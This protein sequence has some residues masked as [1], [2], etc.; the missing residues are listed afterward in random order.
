MRRF[1][2][3]L[4]GALFLA[5]LSTGHAQIDPEKRRLIQL[6]YNQPLEGR[7]PI[8]GYGFF[9]YNKPGFLRT[10]LTLR[11]A[12]A[13]IYVDTELGF[14]RLLSENTDLGIGFAG[15]G[16]ADSYA[17]MRRGDFVRE[18]SFYGHGGELNTTVYHL[19]N[20]GW[21][22][23]LWGLARASFHNSFYGEDSETADN[24]VVPDD[25][26]SLRFRTGL[27]L[28]GREPTL[29]SPLAMEVSLWYEGIIREEAQLFGF[30]NDRKL[31][32]DSHL[33]W[34]RALLKYTFEP[35]EQS[36]DAGLTLGTSFETDRLSAYRIGGVL[37]LVAEFPLSIPG[38]Y[39][40][41]L[42]AEH[43]ALLNAEYSFP[44]T[45]NK[46]WRFSVFGAA[47]VIDGLDQVER[48][49]RFHSGLGAGITFASPRR[50]WFVSLLY[51][52][53]FQAIRK[54]E[55]GSNQVGLL[56]QY[57]FEARKV[58]RSRRFEPEVYPYRSRAGERLFR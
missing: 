49:S 24:F 17:E 6:G 42:T 32:S 30:S 19:F 25:F 54:G 21:R 3:L 55:H 18:E 31:E 26:Y 44:F 7:S 37:P 34:T 51:G 53:G 57:D 20:P 58:P 27:R 38:Y 47:G 29:T 45:P 48:I 14:K 13:P 46:N 12:V 56:F 39:H 50:S 10:N 15:G 16:F 8:S 28:G 33:V 11:L 1:W 43:F 35:S 40:Q 36:F 22:V 2:I 9:Y 41:E 4:W 52:H 5:V 23:P